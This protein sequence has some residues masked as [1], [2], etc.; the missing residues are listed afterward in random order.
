MVGRHLVD[1]HI[2]VRL[3]KIWV[4]KR[5]LFHEQ[6]LQKS[7]VDHASNR[8]GGAA[9]RVKVEAETLIACVRME[10]FELPNSEPFDLR[11]E[12]GLLVSMP[13]SFFLSETQVSVIHTQQYK[14][15]TSLQHKI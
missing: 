1:I 8:G 15:K 9:I 11:M 7:V 3:P 4:R 10:M 13:A 6:L 5:F 2:C 12:Q 14:E